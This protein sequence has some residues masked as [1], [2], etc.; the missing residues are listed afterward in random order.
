MDYQHVRLLSILE[1]SPTILFD[2]IWIPQCSVPQQWTPSIHRLM[3]VITP[4][5]LANKAVEERVILC[6]TPHLVVSRKKVLST[7]C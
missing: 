1:T 4:P 6:R 3:V 2:L 7:M 5:V